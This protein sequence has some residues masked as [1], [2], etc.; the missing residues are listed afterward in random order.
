MSPY[1]VKLPNG[2]KEVGVR[3]YALP[4]KHTGRL[5]VCK[6]GNCYCLLRGMAWFTF[7]ANELGIPLDDR[8]KLVEVYQVERK[9][10][11]DEALAGTILNRLK[12]KGGSDE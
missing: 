8:K 9:K 4:G 12:E 3:T 10:R 1:N 7:D 11:N 2:E 6:S 5:L